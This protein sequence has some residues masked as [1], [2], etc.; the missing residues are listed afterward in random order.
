[1]F[2]E[3]GTISLGFEVNRGHSTN[4]YLKILKGMNFEMVPP[5]SSLAD[6][7]AAVG[8]KGRMEPA[9]CCSQNP[10]AL[11]I[12]KYVV[13]RRIIKYSEPQ[14]AFLYNGL[15][16]GATGYAREWQGCHCDYCSK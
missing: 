1:M 12:T 2:F 8:L 5:R 9:Q 3:D 11:P 15:G 6:A 13:P 16:R 14:F 7:L 10:S 4:P